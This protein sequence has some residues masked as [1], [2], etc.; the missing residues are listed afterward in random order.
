MLFPSLEPTFETEPYPKGDFIFPV[1]GKVLLSGSFGE[2]RSNH[3]HGGI[4]I[5]GFIGKPIL[6]AADGYVS[7]I[8]V[9]SGGYGNVLYLDHPNGYTTVYAHLQK[10]PE[11]VERYVKNIQYERKRFGVDLFPQKHKFSFKQGDVIGKMGVS[12]RSF[13]P[14]LHFEIRDTKTEKPINPLLF[15]LKIF[16]NIPPKM[17]QLKVYAL[18][19]ELATLNEKI[20]NLLGGGKT[21]RVNGDTLSFGAWRIGLGL[22]VYDHM[23]GTSNWNGIYD[24]KVM[25]DGKLHYYFNLEQFAFYETRYINAHLD[26]KDQVTKKSYF[27]RAYQLPGNK[28]S[29]YKE[30]NQAG[31]IPLSNSKAKK[32]EIITSDANGNE[33]KLVFWAKRKEVKPPSRQ[34]FNYILPFDEKNIIKEKTIEL[35][36][37]N[38]TFYE[39][40]YLQYQK[41]DD[42][43]GNYYS[44]VY[45]IHDESV[46]VHKY[47]T[48][49]IMPTQI[50]KSL[51]NKAFVAYCTKNKQI[52]CGGKWENGKLVASVR[53][54]GDFAIMIDDVPPV[55]KPIAFSKNM[56]GYN[57]VSFKI[58]DNFSTAR[59]V[60]GLTF[61][62][63]VDGDWILMNYDAKSD[64]ITHRFDGRIGPGEHVLKLIVTD[65][66][67]N[68][69][70]FE[71]TFSR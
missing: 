38:G 17:H 36:F 50:P 44:S 2:L 58:T 29:I 4:D 65:N 31:V 12:G 15:G 67:G 64:L 16:D 34:V 47:Y 10:F 35:Q 53:D 70:T 8:K 22:K 20:Y 25:V 26:Y 68:S 66:R 27:H 30:A 57:K 3:F 13:G 54:L 33:S 21:Y 69:S 61:Q 60:K 39:D 19:P 14:H 71:Q 45:S 56:K 1:Q 11:A 49:K 55:I 48:I 5:K 51:M 7:R 28:L 59:N 46:P 23:N 63:F 43:G 40:L 42:Q 41:T 24:L 6:A 37:E 18:N 62:A 52:N 9:E 32:I